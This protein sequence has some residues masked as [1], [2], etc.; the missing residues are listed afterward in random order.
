[1]PG[2]GRMMAGTGQHTETMHPMDKYFASNASL[3]LVNVAT[4]KPFPHHITVTRPPVAF[5][6]NAVCLQCSVPEDIPDV[7]KKKKY[8]L[9]INDNGNW[10]LKHE[11]DGKSRFA[12]VHHGN[13]IFSLGVR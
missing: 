7:K 6:T 1:M 4:N 8:F 9:T 10:E 5:I 13:N 11:S 3:T 2:F 12:V